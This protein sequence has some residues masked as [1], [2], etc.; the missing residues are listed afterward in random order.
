MDLGQLR[1]M[2]SLPNDFD[3]LALHVGHPT[4]GPLELHIQSFRIPPISYDGGKTFDAARPRRV[5]GHIER[6]QSG[7]LNHRYYPEVFSDE[8][9]ALDDPWRLSFA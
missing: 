2:L 1:E 9:Q 4:Q 6:F 5:Y 7:H 8:Q 3:V